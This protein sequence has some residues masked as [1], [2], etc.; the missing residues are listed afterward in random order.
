MSMGFNGEG[1]PYTNFHDMNL[2]WMI[3][4]AK[5]F[6]D[7]YTHIQDVIAQGLIDLDEKTREGLEE[8]QTK[9][10]TLEGL[11]D[12]WYTEHSEDIAGQL[13]DALEDL[14]AW[15]T[16]HIE[17]LGTAL[18]GAIAD[19]GTAA[20]AKARTTID[21]IPSDYST[22]YAQAL[23]YLGS[24]PAASDC[25][26]LDGDTIYYAAAGNAAHV[27]VNVAGFIFTVGNVQSVATQIFVTTEQYNSRMY[28]R[29]HVN[30]GWQNWKYQRD[31]YMGNFPNN[32][33][34]NNCE[35]NTIWF[36][37]NALT[38][39]NC[40]T[41]GPGFVYTFGD[42]TT[43]GQQI[44]LTL[45]AT[46]N[47]FYLRRKTSTGWGSWGDITDIYKGVCTVTTNFD[48]LAAP[49]LYFKPIGI[50][51][52]APV[53]DS[54][55]I[56]TFGDP[57]YVA[58]QIFIT[59]K[60]ADNE[61]YVRRITQNGISEWERLNSNG[62]TP[63]IRVLF[64]GNSLTQDAISYLPYLLHTY[65]PEVDFRFYMW[66]CG[67]YTLADQYNKFVNNEA[68]DIFSVCEN[69]FAW[70][71]YS[72]AGSKTMAEVLS[73]YKF[74]I[75]SMQEY[76]NYKTDY[77][78]SDLDDFNHC[79]DYIT[80]NYTGNNGLEFVSMFHAPI[81]SSAAT[82][83]ALTK[84]GNNLILKNTIADDMIPAGIAIYR[85]M[86]TSLDS[87]GD[88]NHL[89]SDGTHAQEG[90]PCLIQT[91]TVACWLFDRVGL[92]RSVYGCP[93]RIDDDVYS[94]LN[95]P[96]P[97]LGSGV[98]EGTDEQNLLAQEIAIQ[99][100]KEGKK[101]VLDNIYD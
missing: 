31:M 41:T 11:L 45:N 1:F 91:L 19:F 40:P 101:E 27:P 16:E 75:V 57:S 79:R 59:T 95:V 71:N 70:T 94:I 85:A 66:Y 26:T 38:C 73:T 88:A 30:A 7:Q 56:Y 55:M 34:L 2:D 35:A 74:D 53:N 93:V 8:L 6:L 49:T 42:L 22:F 61:V 100:Y 36:K 76:F 54:G 28:V 3:K 44:F 68:A 80:A 39:A 17:D 18:A 9:Y 72:G 20:E 52:N 92:A 83:F 4:I 82:T 98:I 97:N 48:L 63:L 60:T 43:I 37:Q 13:A 23:K 86:A 10:E 77:T 62:I 58:Q 47:N 12:A 69:T 21:S 33:D 96:G 65:F 25:D 51:V 78:V 81:R 5:D 14:N 87:L 84:T 29:R 32:S 15:Y 24:L 67:G 89:S 64:V 90:L 50:G 46:G 99:A